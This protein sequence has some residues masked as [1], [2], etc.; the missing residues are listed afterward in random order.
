M[1]LLEA[2]QQPGR[3]LKV[4]DDVQ[5]THAAPFAPQPLA[6][7][8][9]RVEIDTVVF[10][11]HADHRRLDVTERRDRSGVGRQFDEDDVVGIEQHASDQV[12][13]LLRPGGTISRSSRVVVDA[14]R[15]P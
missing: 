12:E 14:A 10:L 15:A 13:A 9:E 4:G 1:P 7:R 3:I 11:R 2:D 5:H 6:G 8:V